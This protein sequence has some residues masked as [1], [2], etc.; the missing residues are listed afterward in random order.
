[1]RRGMTVFL[2]VILMISLTACSKDYGQEIEKH[3][4]DIKGYTATVRLTIHGAEYELLQSYQSPDIYRSEVLSP[5]NLKGTVSVI[6]ADEIRLSGG[7]FSSVTMPRIAKASLSYLQLRDF[8]LAYF[9]Q[10]DRKLEET[11]D[12]GILLTHTENSDSIKQ[13][14]RVN[15]KTF[16]PE[17]MQGYDAEGNEVFKIEYLKFKKE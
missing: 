12:G 13:V 7:E 4:Q 10:G 16:A 6:T 15:K 14:M 11:E 1:M 5:K 17:I 2:T 3:Y 9:S 8:F